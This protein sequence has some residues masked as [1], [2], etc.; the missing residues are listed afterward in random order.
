MKVFKKIS[1]IVV[2]LSLVITAFLASPGLT[3]KAADVVTIGGVVIDGTDVVV[4][5]AGTVASEDGLYHL[6]ASDVSQTAPEG[7]DVAQLAVSAA[8]TFTVPLSKNSESSMLYKKFTVC[9]IKNGA[10]TAASNSMY[11]TNPEACAS[12]HPARVENGKKGLLAD[13]SSANMGMRSL[14]TLGAKQATVTL[15]LSKISYGT[16]TTYTYNGKTYNFNTKYISAYDNLLGRLNSQGVQVSLILVCDANADSTFINPYSYDG[17]GAHS[18]Y[19]LNAATS[20]GAEFLAAAGSF[21]ANRW[22]GYSYFGM[23]AKVD[24]FIIACMV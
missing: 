12:S 21:L 13:V 8:A 1:T 11:I 16:G 20:D 19:G 4:A 7:T 18:Y 22:A 10:L 23:N 14:A 9:V 2:A 5:T 24:N 3:V 6:I 17:L 15:E